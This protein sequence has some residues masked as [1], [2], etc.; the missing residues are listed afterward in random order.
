MQI[1]CGVCLVGLVTAGIM[2][3]YRKEELSKDE[4]KLEKYPQLRD[5]IE[6]SSNVKAT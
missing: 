6:S 4:A 1:L 5:F 3:S 2:F